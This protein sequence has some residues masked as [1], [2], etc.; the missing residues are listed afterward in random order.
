M[1]GRIFHLQELLLENSQHNWT[2]EEMAQIVDL[3]VPHFQKLFKADIGTTPIAH[4]RDL[5]LAKAR[6]LLETKFCRLKQVAF[7]VGMAYDSHFTRDFRK[8]YGV[9]PT[10]YRKQ[11]WG[12]IQSVKS[13]G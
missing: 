2:I 7:E 5:R 12:K 8:K 6:Q 10:E 1:D 4:L 13:V 11:Y 9:T 3:S